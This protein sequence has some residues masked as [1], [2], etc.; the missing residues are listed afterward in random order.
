MCGVTVADM[1]LDRRIKEASPEELAEGI[2]NGTVKMSLEEAAR[3][4]S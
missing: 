4:L 3:S 1:E 2:W